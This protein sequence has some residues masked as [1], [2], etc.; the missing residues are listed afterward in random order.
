M[1]TINILSVD[2][3]FFFPDVVQFDWGHSEDSPWFYEVLWP[4]RWGNR[5]LLDRDVLARKVMW[6]R[7]S[8]ETFLKKVLRKKYCGFVAVTESHKDLY[9]VL[10]NN[11]NNSVN[12]YNYDQHHDCGYTERDN[13][14]VN[15]GNWGWHLKC[16][17]V[18]KNFFQVY[19][20]WRKEVK[21]SDPPKW[22]NVNYESDK[23]PLP[24]FDSVFVCRSSCWTPSW[25]DKMWLRFID[26]LRKMDARFASAPYA[27]KRRDFNL[28][29]A[30]EQ[31]RDLEKEMK[32]CLAGK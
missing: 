4:L 15:C 2:W 6:P 22:V 32:S 31:A 14:E 20:D 16:R 12:I 5:A 17:G 21:E 13:E 24:K 1:M 29:Q 30:I 19:P 28:K 18:I 10:R 23:I 3:D 7:R 26:P 11:L 27:L 9:A 25:A 8:H